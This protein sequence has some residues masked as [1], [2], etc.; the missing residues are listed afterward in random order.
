MAETQVDSLVIKI[1]TD[2]SDAIQKLNALESAL[3]SLKSAASGNTKGLSTI[4]K[5]LKTLGEATKAIDN[6]G[7]KLTSLANI[8]SN[9]SNLQSIKIPATIAKRITEI[10]EAASSVSA[11]GISNLD[12]MTQSMQRLSGVDFSGMK[13]VPKMAPAIDEKPVETPET[14]K[15]EA[16]VPTRSMDEASMQLAKL[17]I[18]IQAA[19]AA[20]RDLLKE[21]STTGTADVGQ[22]QQLTEA[23]EKVE[24]LESA[25]KELRDAIQSSGGV[26]PQVSPAIE[27]ES[28]GEKGSA[29][30]TGRLRSVMDILSGIGAAAKSAAS[31]VSKFFD[32]FNQS[33]IIS[34]FSSA[35]RSI[36]TKALRELWSV[37]P[38]KRFSD[39]VGNA[40]GRFEKLISSIGRISFYRAVRAAIKAIT[41]SLKTG[42]SNLYQYSK[43]IGTEFAS[44]MDRLSTSVFYL[45]NSFGAMAAPLINAV[46]PAIDYL[47]DKF[48]ALLN[49]IGKVFA[50]LGGKATYTQAIKQT[51]E[52]ADAA[53]GAAGGAAGAAKELKNALMGFDE[54][55]VLPSATSGGGGGGG[56]SAGGIDYGTMFEEVPIEGLDWAGQVRESIENGDWYSAGAILAEKLNE[57]VD[58]LPM[59]EWGQKLGE[60]INNGLNFAYGSLKNFDFVN[61]GKKISEGLNGLFDGVNFDLL[62][63]V[64][65]GKWNA[66]VDLIY[67]FVTNFNWSGLG[68]ALSTSVNAWFDE[69][70]WE[71]VGKTL[72]AGLEGLLESAK[73][74]LQGLNWRDIGESIGELIKNIEWDQVFHDTVTV[75]SEALKGMLEAA[76]GFSDVALDISDFSSAVDSLDGKDIIII[77]IA[78]AIGALAII[79]TIIDLVGK[80]S[81]AIS[82]IASPVGIVIAVIGALIAVGILLAQNWDAI[83]QK[84]SEVWESISGF[85]SGIWESISTFFS[86]TWATVSEFF[87]NLWTTITESEPVQAMVNAFTEA[88]HAIQAVWELVQPFFAGVWEGIQNVFSVVKAVLSAFFK[89][90]W[91]AIKLVWSVVV[92]FFKTIWDGI[93][94]V[95]SVVATILGGFFRTAWT[96]IKAV[97]DTVVDFFVMIWDGI[98]AVFAVVE[99]V[100]SGDFSDA[101]KA[102]ET[103]WGDVVNFFSG[104]WSGITEVFASVGT[105]FSDTFSEAWEAVKSIFKG[106]GEFFSGLWDSITETFSEI[107]TNI[108]SAIGQTIES[109]VNSVISWVEG[110][111]NSLIRTVNSAIRL[112]NKIPGVNIGE[113][114]QVSLNR[115]KVSTYESGGLPDFGQLFLARESG[116]ELVGTIG[117]RNAVVNNDQIVESVSK[118]VYDGVRDA[119]RENKN[120]GRYTF[121]ATVDGRTLF[122]TVVDMNNSAV[123]ATGE[124]PLLV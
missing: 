78:T 14:E 26:E 46:A 15:A 54:L 64:F 66:L 55:N 113:V 76:T 72:T 98:A 91:S 19:K 27:A 77:T 106:W 56:A 49:I 20:Y 111:I 4:S 114:K 21:L 74:F 122:E 104:I 70:K 5:Q 47:I 107:G 13:S 11:E 39:S 33:P 31:D 50:I 9:L 96:A 45:Q 29:V 99:G 53:G 101:E 51:K 30:D 105:W 16:F 38:I 85:F 35:L 108:A 57:I 100:L 82:L 7:N 73:T 88:W 86:E 67:G 36:P 102:I 119:M 32:T 110:V 10:G 80:F 112:I 60:M 1:E 40:A 92:S 90:A 83:K 44:S 23:R 17:E 124:S 37:S 18:E 123:M 71:D 89:S 121:V 59:Y 22:I 65:A 81:S 12:K 62:G 93:K 69:I 34:K 24:E 61:L 43:L 41:D 3:S 58:G 95:F 63:R 109:G 87:S 52:Y 118:G 6:S 103:L 117:G 28:G 8:I 48:V 97:W 116:P 84:A 68:T 115:V 42:V 25:Y 79:G 94:A 2:S 120:G 75:I